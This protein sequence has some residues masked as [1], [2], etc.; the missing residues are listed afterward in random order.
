MNGASESGV[1]GVRGGVVSLTG[2]WEGDVRCRKVTPLMLFF[3]A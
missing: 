3:F 2:C 1:W